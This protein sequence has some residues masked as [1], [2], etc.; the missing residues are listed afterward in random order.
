[1]SKIAISRLR[2]NQLPVAELRELIDLHGADKAW[3]SMIVTH[4]KA[5]DDKKFSTIINSADLAAGVQL[6]SDLLA[7]LSLG[8]ISVL[9]EFSLAYAN[10]AS[11][12]DEGQYFTPDDVAEFLAS[13]SESFPE[14]VWLDPCSGVG[15][16]IFRIVG[17]QKNPEKFLIGHAILTDK[18]GLAL[19]I[20]RALLT[21]EF[22]DENHN[23]FDEIK[24][25]FIE[26][27]FLDDAPLPHFDYAILNP[28]YVL[29]AQDSRFE[30]VKCRDL[31]GYFLEKVAKDSKGFISITPQSFTNGS[32]FEGLRKVLIREVNKADIYCFD[33]VPGNVFEGVKF[34]STNTNKVNSTRA[35]V[36]VARKEAGKSLSY[37][38]TPLLRW[39]TTER[40]EL[41]RQ[42]D[43]FLTG[44]APTSDDFP[45]LDKDSSSFYVNRKKLPRT[46]ATYVSSYATDFV[47][48]LGTTPRYFISAVET[49]LERS[50]MKKVYFHT[51]SERDYFYL[52]LNTSYLYWWWRVNDGGMTLSEKT[53]MSLPVDAPT[54][55]PKELMDKL[56]KSEK[57]SVVYKK[58]GGMDSQNIKHPMS[59]VKEWTEYFFPED[60][61]GLVKSHRNSVFSKD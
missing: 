2:A 31:F 1:M 41:L 52:L 30:S 3:K 53:L 4:A 32:K 14:G 17:R 18:D 46:L 37:R 10:R 7:G 19:L 26:R 29:V 11:R 58:N 20:A 59:L 54:Q 43:S 45:K 12:K 27:D 51:E 9:Y 50:S 16:L 48:Y 35:G 44:F 6:D 8:S 39:R 61:N 5:L 38:I 55:P 57:E 49:P 56:R 13:K 21:I 36:I 40:A 24:G 22:Q 25:Q 42:A 28:P 15:N 60:F 23:L 33:N 47:L 34:G